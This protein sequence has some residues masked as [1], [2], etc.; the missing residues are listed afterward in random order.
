MI[1]VAGCRA[2]GAAAKPPKPCRRR[3]P[4]TT[5][6]AYTARMVTSSSAAL[7][8]RR[9]QPLGVGGLRIHHQRALRLGPGLHLVAGLEVG[10]AEVDVRRR[11]VFAPDRNLERID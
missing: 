6:D 10:L 11:L 4:S 3:L 7:T 5:S 9:Q 1:G 8:T 2:C